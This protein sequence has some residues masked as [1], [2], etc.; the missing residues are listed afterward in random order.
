MDICGTHNM[1][2]IRFILGKKTTAVND[3]EVWAGLEC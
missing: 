3:G 1:S 2:Q